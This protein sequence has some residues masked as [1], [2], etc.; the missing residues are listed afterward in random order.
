VES[1]QHD[2]ELAGAEAAGVLDAVRALTHYCLSADVAAPLRDAGT[3]K[4]AAQ[5]NEAAMMGLL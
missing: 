5:P 2:C 4:I 3:V 1:R